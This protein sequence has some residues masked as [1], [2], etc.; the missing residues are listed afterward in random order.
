MN[1]D[2]NGRFVKAVKVVAKNPYK[3]GD[4]VK[5]GGVGVK[6]EVI[7]VYENYVWVIS[8][9]TSVPFTWDYHDVSPWV[10]PIKLKYKVGDL[11]LLKDSNAYVFEI[12][13]VVG[14]EGYRIKNISVGYIRPQ[15]FFDKDILRKVG[16]AVKK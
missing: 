5:C 7:C 1:R 14:V 11:V 2:N 9:R 8:L 3:V 12:I 13:E 16:V 15:T 4:F 6:L 10:E